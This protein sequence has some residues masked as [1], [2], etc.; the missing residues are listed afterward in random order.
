MAACFMVIGA[1]L[2]AAFFSS[3][4][5]GMADPA[6]KHGRAAINE[7]IVG[8]GGF[9]GSMGFAWLAERYGI[10]APFHWAPLLVGVLLLVQWLLIRRGQ[11]RLLPVVFKQVE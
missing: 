7:G 5:Y 1:N 3:S 2:G 10:A 9:S 8:L 11:H 6:R 4:F